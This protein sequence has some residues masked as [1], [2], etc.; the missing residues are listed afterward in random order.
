MF[1]TELSRRRFL[2]QSLGVTAATLATF[3]AMAADEPKPNADG[4]VSLFNG[5]DLT[6]WTPKITGFA[7]GENFGDTFRVADGMIQVRYDKYEQFDTKF[8][9]L[10]FKEQYGHYIFRLEYRFVGDQCK[11][12][13]GWATR[14]SGIMFHGQTP[15]SMSKDQKFPVSIEYQLL[16][17]LGKGKRSTGNMCSPGTNIVLDGKLF[18]THCT[19]SKSKTYDGD[20][21]VKAEV[22]V[23]GSGKVTHRIEG[24]VVMEYEQPQLDPKDADAAKLIKAR[25]GVLL[26]DKGTI[27]LQSE[28]HPCDFR[29]IEIKVLDKDKK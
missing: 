18:T 27:S 19:N 12:G 28:S 5:K 9:H 23:H 4:F 15:E 11:G 16:G 2:A 22:E 6:G 25:D 29:K 1:P 10:F 17:G 21:W 13:P 24:E 20:A 8:G 3:P 26:L 14:N 7:S